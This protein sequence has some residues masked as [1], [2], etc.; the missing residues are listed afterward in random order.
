MYFKRGFNSNIGVISYIVSK[1]KFWGKYRKW[2]LGYYLGEFGWYSIM[3][4]FIW[5][6][7]IFVRVFVVWRVI[8]CYGIIVF[9]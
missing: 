7:C 9:E 5:D 3:V 8:L 1:V 6:R 4:L 2:M